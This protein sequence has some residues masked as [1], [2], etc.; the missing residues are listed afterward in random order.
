[1]IAWPIRRTTTNAARS[2]VDSMRHLENCA[3]AGQ[4]PRQA[5]WNLAWQVSTNSA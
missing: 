2:L 4:M 5:A 1:M 3:L